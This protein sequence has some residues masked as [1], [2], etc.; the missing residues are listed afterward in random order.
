M[1]KWRIVTEITPTL[2]SKPDGVLGSLASG[3]DRVASR[4]YLILPP[5][6][7]DLFLW[8]GPR[9][10]LAAIFNALA[11]T[12][13]APAAGPPELS[14]QVAMAKDLLGTLGSQFNL[15]SALSAFPIAVPS[16]MATTMPAG[17]PLG[18]PEII[19]LS[20]PMTIL[21]SW[22]GLTVV[23]L[24]MATLYHVGLAYAAS[25]AA[26]A[27][28][29]PSLWLR[30]LAMAALTY[31]GLA[32][33]VIASLLAASLV[34]LVTPFLGT[35]VAFLGFTIL[36]WLAVYLIFTPHGL[37]RYRLGLLRAMQESVS[38]VRRSFF[39]T[40]GFLTTVVLVSWLTNLVWE[41]P[42]A[43]S[44]FGALAALGHAFIS[45]MVLVA[46]YIFYVGRREAMLAAGR[47]APAAEEAA[48]DRRDARG[49]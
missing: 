19:Q 3:F 49:A 31:L 21:L 14:A 2:R 24:G 27:G 45:A 15:F 1:L 17:S 18:S 38:I 13:S 39:S 9:L 22:L 30:V 44:W 33:I 32:V 4:P 36:F 37:V 41:L 7:L 47:P 34:T 23:G 48:M 12:L 26:A 5:L 35:G 10:N 11:A 46:S 29:D 40:V 6:V 43:E 25:P 28:R 42:P 8:L 20:D 16:L